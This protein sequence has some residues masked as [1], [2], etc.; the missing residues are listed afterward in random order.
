MGFDIGLIDI[1]ELEIIPINI[2]IVKLANILPTVICFP[3]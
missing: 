3:R 1:S 2:D